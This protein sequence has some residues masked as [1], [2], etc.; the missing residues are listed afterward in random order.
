MGCL[1]EYDME[2]LHRLEGSTVREMCG[3]QLKDRV[4][5]YG[6]DADLRF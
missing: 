6:C 1:K 4:Y 2:V 5:F 3:I